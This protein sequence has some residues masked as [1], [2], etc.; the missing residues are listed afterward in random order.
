METHVQVI[1]YKCGTYGRKDVE[2]FFQNKGLT[3]YHITDLI[4]ND[5]RSYT[6]DNMLLQ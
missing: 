1:I 4:K 3:L 2:G 5:V 6:E